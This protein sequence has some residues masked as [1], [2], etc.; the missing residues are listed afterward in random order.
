MKRILSLE[1]V[2]KYYGNGNGS[3]KA[4]DGVDFEMEEGEFVAIMG[5]S[6]SGKSTLLS[7]IATIEPPSSGEIIIDGEKLSEMKEKKMASF[8]RDNLGFVFQDYNLLDTLTVEENI[9]LPLYL[10]KKGEEETE[11][12]LSRSASILGIEKLLKKFPCELSGGE[13]QRVALSR[14]IST[15]PSL[16]LADEPTGALDS[17]NTRNIMEL[18][19]KMNKELGSTILMVTHDPF[20]GSFASRTVFLKDGKIWNMIYKGDK[21]REEMYGD[22]LSALRV[23][24]GGE[25]DL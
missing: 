8:R 10:Q 3:V 7:V 18:F 25:Y 13:R 4:L 20:V 17:K 19:E 14:A 21:S 16:I 9:L 24:G 6:G 2:T 1:N 12:I 22:I 11:R 5:P 15:S 23:L